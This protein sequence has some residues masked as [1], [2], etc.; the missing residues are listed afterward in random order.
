MIFKT[1]VDYSPLFVVYNKKDLSRKYLCR[2][3]SMR[4][5][6]TKEEEWL[7]FDV[8]TLANIC[9]QHEIYNNSDS[10]GVIRLSK[11]DIAKFLPI[12]PIVIRGRIVDTK[13][14]AVSTIQLIKKKK[15]I[16]NSMIDKDEK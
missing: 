1:Y 13:R 6:T 3:G 10:F 11:E 5:E 15:A 16:I 2:T 14:E 7:Y 4:N 8:I 9:W 12:V